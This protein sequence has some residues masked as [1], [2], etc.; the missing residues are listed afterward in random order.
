MRLA[1][2]R[3]L[4]MYSD[5]R[6]EP[7]PA[8][9][10]A[11]LAEF[12]RVALEIAAGESIEAVCGGVPSPLDHMR[13]VLL[14]PTHLPA[15]KG[16]ALKDELHALF[17]CPVFIENDA[18]LVGLG[19]AVNGAGHDYP[20]VGYVT[21][22]TGVG[23]A[24]IVHGRLDDSSTGFEPGRM[25]IDADGTLCPDC[26]G[27]GDLESLVSGTAVEH[28]FGKKPFEISDDAV[29]DELARYLAIGIY[30]LIVEWSPDAI[31]LGGSMVVK[32]TGIKVARV[33]EHLNSYKERIP[34]MPAI[35]EASL[36]D[37]GGLKGALEYA[38]Q[39]LT[40]N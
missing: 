20:I 5:V 28:R 17:D 36:V 13:N 34:E 38:R 7:T 10:D 35:I 15:W 9:F 32:T 21:V 4:K 23:G 6:V 11:A 33:I 39:N 29:W 3:D 25:I 31:V 40:I 24:R 12:K 1:G 2:S 22:S 14:S 16:R 27:R 18:A 8:D 19:E 26:G 30:N 37:E